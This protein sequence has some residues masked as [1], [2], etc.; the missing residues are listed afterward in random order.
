MATFGMRL[1]DEQL[2][3]T[4]KILTFGG[5]VANYETNTG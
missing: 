3:Y 5:E 4:I 2:E 1:P